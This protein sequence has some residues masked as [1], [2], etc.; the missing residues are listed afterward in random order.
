MLT[1]DDF[2]LTNQNFFWCYPGT[3]IDHSKAVWLNFDGA[4]MPTTKNIYA[5][6]G[7]S[8]DE[9]TNMWT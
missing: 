8:V 2:A 9:N 7:D 1:E 5:I 3:Y 6:C 4:T